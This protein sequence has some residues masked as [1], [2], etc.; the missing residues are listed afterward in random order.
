MMIYI[1]WLFV[2]WVLIQIGHITVHETGDGNIVCGA[3]S[4]ITII[5]FCGGILKLIFLTLA[6]LI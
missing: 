2:G 1:G 3:G 6:A 5:A 4:L